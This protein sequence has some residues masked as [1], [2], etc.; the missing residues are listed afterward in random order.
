MKLGV[1]LGVL[2]A[3]IFW[4]GCGVDEEPLRPRVGEKAAATDLSK[5][6]VEERKQATA[7]QD[8][9]GPEFFVWPAGKP[10]ERDAEADTRACREQALE[11]EDY[12]R[13]NG[14]IKFAIIAE[15]MGAKGWTV[16][17]DAVEAFKREQAGL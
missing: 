12:A 9:L 7:D 4:L 1:A 11:R 13:V 3:A 14:V 6:T 17:S 16:D 8:A 15:C 2:V 5:M 10:G